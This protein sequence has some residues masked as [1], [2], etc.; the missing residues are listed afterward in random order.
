MRAGP[1]FVRL[2]R[3]GRAESGPLSNEGLNQVVRRCARAAG[4][5][6]RLAHPHVLRAY[7]A[8]TLASAG[9]P[10]HV[11][12][13]RLGHSDIQTTSRYLAEVADEPGGVGAVLDRRHQRQRR[14]RALR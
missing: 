12:A 4:V 14:E 10:V 11:I 1:L 9:V 7:Y 6:A 8:T 2:G 13:R 3:H 5:P